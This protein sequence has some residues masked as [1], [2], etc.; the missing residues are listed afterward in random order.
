MGE[1]GRMDESRP[2]AGEPCES[3]FVW[4]VPLIVSVLVRCGESVD[5][6]QSL[7]WVPVISGRPVRVVR[8]IRGSFDSSGVACVEFLRPGLPGWVR[9]PFGGGRRGLPVL[10]PDGFSWVEDATSPS[11]QIGGSLSGE[12]V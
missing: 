9:G 7:P 6:R 2:L 8:P 1:I 10:I 5:F 3:R 12:G 11:A 4:K